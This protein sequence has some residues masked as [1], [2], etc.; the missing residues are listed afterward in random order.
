[1]KGT[2]KGTKRK[3]QGDASTAAAAAGSGDAFYLI[4]C[5]RSSCVQQFDENF[6]M[7]HYEDELEE[8][9]REVRDA[10]KPFDGTWMHGMPVP[11]SQQQKASS[12]SS[13]SSSDCS[14]QLFKSLEAANQQAGELYKALL[15]STPFDGEA[16][17][18][19]QKQPQFSWQAKQPKQ[20]KSLETTTADG[21][22]R[23]CRS[24]MRPL[25]SGHHPPHGGPSAL[26]QGSHG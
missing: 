16:A 20:P 26:T 25:R 10:V 13:S 18:I 12:S 3:A 9:K 19:P 24:A 14:I 2:S 6:T 22:C 8:D 5:S 21:R 23:A 1:M 4:L 17:D 7:D 11:G 15:A